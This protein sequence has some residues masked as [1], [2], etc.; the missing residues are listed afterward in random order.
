MSKPPTHSQTHDQTHD[1]L[2]DQLNE[3]T[4]AAEVAADGAA[5][6]LLNYFGNLHDVSEKEQAGLVSEADRESEAYIVKSLGSRFP[7]HRFLGEE[8]GLS[9]REKKESG[10]ALWIIDPLDGTTNYVHRFPFFSISIALEIDGEIQIGLVDAPKLGMRFTAARGQGA[11][12]NGRR[13]RVSPRTEFHEGLFATG[14]AV[15]RE[16]L[17]LQYELIDLC[18]KDARGIRRAGSAALDLCFV[19]DGVWDVFWEQN[20]Q[21]WDM[22]A[23][24]LIARE[25]GATVTNFTGQTYT[26]SDHDI[27]AGTPKLHSEFL[28]HVQRLT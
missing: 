19:A 17:D 18:V 12:L 4:R 3:F 26:T 20:L 24:A 27:I 13:I 22:A 11:F 6:I 16:G 9:S 10:D 28:S 8:T 23:G 25:A 1:Q 2:N 7:S 15:G 5:Q 21:P 14:F